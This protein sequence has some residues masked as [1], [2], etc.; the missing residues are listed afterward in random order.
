MVNYDMHKYIHEFI[1]FLLA[2][3]GM[4]ART[5]TAYKRDLLSFQKATGV[6]YPAEI[7]SKDLRNYLAALLKKGLSR[8]TIARN[9]A[10]LR[11]FFRFLMRQEVLTANPAE[12]IKPPKPEKRL[13]QYL[14]VDQTTGLLSSHGVDTFQAVRDN[15]ILELLYSTGIRVSELCG[16]NMDDLHISPEMVKVH[17]KGGKDRVVPFGQKAKD[18]I[19]TYLI[20]RSE[21]LNRLKL[22]QNALFLNERGGRLTPRS[23]QRS[24]KQRCIQ[25]GLP[26]G[27]TPH[28]LRHSMATHMLE[29]GA[30]LR[31]IQEI[32]G[33]ASLATTQRYTHLDMDR[34]IDVYQKAHP[35]AKHEKELK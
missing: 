22:S 21:L 32:L 5:A 35:R 30:D 14:S 3:R 10:C 17:G 34:L 4:S 33:H 6:L 13:P 9:L 27:I 18:A 1:D 26:D 16:L 29:A 28:S 24:L 11:S 23:V 19:K 8:A 2:E 20:K 25:G 7:T 12:E 15:A 31:S